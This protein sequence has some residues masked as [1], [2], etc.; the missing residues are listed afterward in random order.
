MYKSRLSFSNYTNPLLFL[1]KEYTANSITQCECVVFQD[2][3][4]EGRAQKEM[5]LKENTLKG[6]ALEGRSL[7]GRALEGRSLKGRALEE[8]Q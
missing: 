8:R 2:R 7:K 5:A 4:G 1:R 3:F 6:R